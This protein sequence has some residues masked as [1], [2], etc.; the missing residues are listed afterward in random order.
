MNFKTKEKIKTYATRALVFYA[1]AIIYF[2]FF[3]YGD[4]LL[5]NI[6]GSYNKPSFAVQAGSLLLFS[7]LAFFVAVTPF[8]L[9][10]RILTGGKKDERSYESIRNDHVDLKTSSE[11]NPNGTDHLKFKSADG[12]TNADTEIFRI[13][14]ELRQRLSEQPEI[15]GRRANF[16]LIIGV[17]IA[18]L[19]MVAFGVLS[20][21]FS[22]PLD[23]LS[24]ASTNNANGAGEFDKSTSPT[25][26]IL[27]YLPKLSLLII[28]ETVAFFFLRL[29]SRTISEIRFFQNELSSIELKLLSFLQIRQNGTKEQAMQICEA[30]ILC[31]RNTHLANGETT[32]EIELEKANQRSFENYSSQLSKVLKSASN[33]P[34]Q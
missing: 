12:D 7:T 4:T 21:V 5:S 24:A 23:L 2:T 20:G 19:V 15:L 17:M 14:S 3:N 16:S 10:R 33:R 22:I 27:H 28:G 31:E 9:L 6:L 18:F 32:V 8:Y 11:L 26:A 25:E 30:L 29:H 13:L 1:V 34:K